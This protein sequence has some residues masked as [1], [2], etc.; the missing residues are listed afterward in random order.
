MVQKRLFRDAHL[1]FKKCFAETPLFI[2]F[3]GAHFLDQV[4]K[5]GKIWTPTKKLIDNWKAHFLVFLCFFVFFSFL[6]LLLIE[7]PVSPLKKAFFVYCECLPLFL[8][9]VFLSSLLLINEKQHQ[10]V[11]LQSF[12]VINPFSFSWV[13]CLVFSFKSL[14]L[15]FGFPDFKFCFLF[16]MNVLVSKQ[17]S[18]KHNFLVKRGCN[19]RFF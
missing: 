4:V 14:F 19:K 5:K 2:V 11:I 3:W 12:F 10:T 7:K 1:F 8:L 13:S 18:Y 6:S 15:I 16:N 9:S 17:T